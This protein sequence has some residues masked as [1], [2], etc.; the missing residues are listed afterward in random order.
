MIK[1]TYLFCKMPR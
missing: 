1:L